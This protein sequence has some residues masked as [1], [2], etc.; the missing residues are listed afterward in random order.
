MAKKKIEWLS[1]D[2]IWQILPP[3]SQTSLKINCD[4][5]YRQDVPLIWYN[6]DDIDLWDLPPTNP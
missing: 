2:K 6:E 5:S 4:K 1:S 3:P